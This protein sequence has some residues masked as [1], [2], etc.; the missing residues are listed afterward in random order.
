MSGRTNRFAEQEFERLTLAV[1]RAVE[2]GNLEEYVRLLA[3]AA[4]LIAGRSLT[5]LQSQRPAH[6]SSD[7][8]ETADSM[9]SVRVSLPGSP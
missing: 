5:V 1:P 7:S 8:S 9:E 6:H 2:E 4:Q 3:D